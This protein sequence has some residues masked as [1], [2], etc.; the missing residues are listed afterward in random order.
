MLSRANFFGLSGA[1]D[2]QRFLEGLDQVNGERN[3]RREPQGAVVSGVNAPLFF[4]SKK[5]SVFVFFPC[6]GVPS[7]FV[8]AGRVVR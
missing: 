3:P 7:F 2:V 8:P 5:Q 4:N 1:E 6:A